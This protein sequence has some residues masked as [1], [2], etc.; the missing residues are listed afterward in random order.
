MDANPLRALIAHPHL[1]PSQKKHFLA[2]AAERTLPYP[3][4][5]PAASQALEE[6]VVS[7]LFEGPAPYRPRYVLPDYEKALACGCDFLELRPPTDLDEALSFLLALYAHVP[8]I[9]GYPVYLGEID[10]L[11]LPFTQ[12]LD[13]RA[14]E[15]KLRL[16]WITLD[17]LFPDAFVHANLG[18]RDN[19][20]GRA[21]LRV[22]REL[23]QVV[24]NLTLKVDPEQ[25]SDDYLREAIETVFA[26]AKPYLV[27]DPMIRRDFD[28]PYGV[29][30]CYNTLPVGGGAHTLV[31]LNLAQA[32]ARCSSVEEFLCAAL[33]RYVELTLEVIRARVCFLVEEARF[34]EH[35]FLAREGLIDL[36]RF[37]AMFG[38]FGMA[39]AVNRLLAPAAMRYG[40][41]PEANRLAY[42]ITAQIRE[43]L[44]RT[45]LPHCQ[46]N[47][48][49]AF[50]HAQA[51]ADC[52]A[53]TTPGT[54]IALGD[55]PALLEH[56]LA[57]AP[58]HRHFQAG[59]SDIFHLDPTARENPQ[60]VLDIM[61]GA[62][63]HGLRVFTF[64][65]VDSPLV[66]ITGFLV[67]RS[68]L[69]SF[70]ASGSRYH[71]TGLGVGQ[72]EN[73]NVFQRKVRVLRHEELAW[74]DQPRPAE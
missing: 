23:V 25:T 32:A 52:D 58:H 71:S 11:L 4:L 8:S 43:L 21:I 24:P 42:R 54:R 26:A 69:H 1:E 7:D 27:N 35:S 59:V 2:H 5:S 48:G 15:R 61:K 10:R 3:A 41:H 60:A 18:P 29:A 19:P 22:E 50:L 51:G 73:R 55:E 65:L 63:R 17:R 37:S 56:I 68:E 34:F 45:Q 13:A 30:S 28:G 53:G 36:D 6:G 47:G 20:V 39:E 12:G 40:K 67:K 38:V 33:P 72:H 31:R 14:L 62:F 46:G 64:N 70:R 49:R 66:R 57:V 16:F 44:D 74:P 9:T